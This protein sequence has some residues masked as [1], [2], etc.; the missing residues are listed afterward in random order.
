MKRLLS[1]AILLSFGV[2]TL[3]PEAQTEGFRII[4]HAANQQPPMEA[5]RLA[6]IFLKKVKRWD[7]GTPINPVDQAD[8][9]PVRES[10]TEAIHG[11]KV[12]AIA[13]Y[14]TREIFSG[15]GVPPPKRT[16]DQEV[17]D[18]VRNDRG[19]V[20]YVSSSAALGDGV[21]ELEVIE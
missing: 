7:D 2:L 10:F 16:S 13:G 6:K 1:I 5:D 9:S 4:V 15:R 8:D 19:A 11:K 20:G 12:S 17:I 21:K 14:W 18:F 3:P